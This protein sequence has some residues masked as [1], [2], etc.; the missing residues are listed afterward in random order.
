MEKILVSACLV[1]GKVRYDGADNWCDN[2]DFCKWLAEGRLVMVCPEVASGCPVPRSPVEI[3]GTNGGA[4]VLHGTSKVMTNND[5]DISDM[6]I[7]GARIT[8]ELVLQEDIRIA[9]LK[10]KSP[11]C[12]S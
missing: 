4:G 6:F 12:G 10:S 2:M 1:G 9:I 11:S 3:V 7:S 5:V 8:L